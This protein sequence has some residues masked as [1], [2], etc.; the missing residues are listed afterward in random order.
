MSGC[1]SPQQIE[2]HLAGSD[3]S[4]QKQAFNRHIA[5]CSTCAQAFLDAQ[6]NETWLRQLLQD[7]EIASLHRRISEAITA[8]SR[9]ADASSAS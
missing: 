9:S 1:L 8:Q 3:S 6:A 2:F 5:H 7:E 4:R